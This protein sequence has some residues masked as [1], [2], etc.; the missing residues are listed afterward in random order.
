MSQMLEPPRD[1]SPMWLDLAH[2]VAGAPTRLFD[3]PPADDQPRGGRA[4]ARAAWL[5]DR[6]RPQQAGARWLMLMVAAQVGG[7]AVT[8]GMLMLFGLGPV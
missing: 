8:A 6:E 7:A 2:I 5:A 1:L 4:A 3:P